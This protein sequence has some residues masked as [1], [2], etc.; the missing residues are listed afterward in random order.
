MKEKISDY[1]IT[2]NEL[3][4]QLSAL[5]STVKPSKPTATTEKAESQYKCPN[6]KL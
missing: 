5:T 6:N 3:G 1:E 2:A 4:F